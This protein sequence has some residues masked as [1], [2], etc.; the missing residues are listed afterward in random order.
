MKKAILKTAY[1]AIIL[2]MVVVFSF[3]AFSSD[4]TFAVGAEKETTTETS[5]EST[6]EK[7]SK[8]STTEETT[9]DSENEN[10]E[11]IEEEDLGEDE[12]TEDDGTEEATLTLEEQ[13]SILDSSIEKIDEKLKYL[14]EQ[15]D[16]TEEYI[17]T[18]D[19]KI[20]ALNEQLTV[21][22]NQITE[23]SEEQDEVKQSI[24]KNEK[25]VKKL[26]K[27]I[28]K[29]EDELERLNKLFDAKYEVYC[30][31][32]RAIYISGGWNVITT[33]LTCNDLSTFLTRYEMV[34]AVSKSDAEL[35]AEIQEEVDE[36][37]AEGSVL[38]QKRTS[39]DKIQ[40]KLEKEEADLQ[41]KEDAVESAQEELADKKATLAEDR[42]QSDKLYAELTAENGMYSEYRNEDSELSDAVQ[43]EI[44]D[45]INGLISADDVTYAST[46]KRSSKA[47]ADDYT[48]TDVYSKSN[49]VLNMTYPA[50][51][52]YK[53][54]CSFGKYSNGGSHTGTDFPC[55]KGTEIVA[56]Q[57]GQV[58]KVKR[59]D[60][61]YGYYVMIYHGTDAN[62]RSVVTLY[63]H[64][65]SILVTVGQT[66]AKGEVIALS[67]STGNSTG[68]HCHFEIRLNGKAVNPIHYLSK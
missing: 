28:K 61:S 67:G 63:A 44:S 16:S 15:S 41:A 53:V 42:A 64:N 22:E 39:L 49:A 43:Q 13:K 50:P 10:I 54:S 38:N 8:E 57:S 26:K 5:D 48:Y 60:Y 23:Y 56:A 3:A 1:K 35:L 18:L 59:L 51:G 6:T 45:L 36:I 25:K 66:V 65:S 11:L 30:E 37:Q 7:K 40:K 20:G 14:A 68:P 21:L 17:N 46:E 47:S 19:E 27:E 29:Y 9:E 12:S 62:G 58:I 31:R 52:H 55:P 33:L 32:M 2:L 4:R 34:K 24:K